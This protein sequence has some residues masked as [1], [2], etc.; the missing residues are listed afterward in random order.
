MGAASDSNTCHDAKPRSDTENTETSEKSTTQVEELVAAAVA[1]RARVRAEIAQLWDAA[2]A[3][4]T[5]PEVL[6]GLRSRDA[7]DQ[8]IAEADFEI[9]RKANTWDMMRSTLERKTFA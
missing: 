1:K 4:L 2:E 5:E 3:I 9:Q 6:A 7:L 8:A